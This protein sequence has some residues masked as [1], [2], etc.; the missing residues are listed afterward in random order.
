[1]VQIFFVCNLYFIE[2]V[3]NKM[4]RHFTGTVEEDLFNLRNKIKIK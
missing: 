1:M 2:Y 4:F 3:W